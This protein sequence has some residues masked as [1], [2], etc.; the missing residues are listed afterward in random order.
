MHDRDNVAIRHV[1]TPVFLILPGFYHF[2]KL[3][4]FYNPI[5]LLPSKLMSYFYHFSKLLFFYNLILC[6]ILLLSYFSI[7]LFF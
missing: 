5:L 7:F 4:F 1:F 2:S 3:L 6:Q